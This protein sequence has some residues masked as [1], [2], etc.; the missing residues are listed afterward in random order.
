M[1]LMRHLFVS[2]DKIVLAVAA[3]ALTC[4]PVQVVLAQAD[5]LSE[6]TDHRTQTVTIDGIHFD[7]PVGTE[8]EKV[9]DQ[10]FIRWPVAADFDANGALIVLESNWNRQTVQQ[11]LESQP[12]A[13]VRLS[14]SDHDG[15]FDKR[16]VIADKLSFSAGVLVYGDAIFV[17]APPV[18]LKLTD[19]D[20][21]GFFDARETWHDGGTL[22]YCANDLHGPFLGPDGWI[23]WTKGAFAEQ[24][25]ET[26]LGKKVTSK[27]AH[28]L[29]RHPNGGPVDI[30][31]TGGM[32]NPV[33]VA[34]LPNGERIFCS[35][36]MHHPGDGLRDGI[37][38]AIYGSLFGKSH[39]PVD[40]HIRTGPLFD[41]IV[42]L[43][44]AAPASVMHAGPHNLIHSLDLFSEG[45]QTH[46]KI[47]SSQFNLQRLQVHSLAPDGGTFRTETQELISADRIDFHPVDCLEDKDGSLLILDTGGWYDLCCPSSGS[48]GQVAPGGIY[49]LKLSSN[50]HQRT[51]LVA[52][53]A[54]AEPTIEI[55]EFWKAARNLVTDP[56]DSQ[57]IDLVIR[58]LNNSNEELR[59]AAANLISLYRWDNTRPYLI[60]MLKGSNNGASPHSRRLAAECLGRLG[61]PTTETIQTLLQAIEIQPP[62]RTLDHAVLYALIELDQEQAMREA[63]TGDSPRQQ[64]A[65]LHVL[66]QT[67]HIMP[68]DAQRLFEL[69]KSNDP[70]V[71]TQAISTL[72]KQPQL[73][74][75]SAAY[76]NELWQSEDPVAI[77][78]LN[79]I[80]LGWNQQQ[81]VHRLIETG[82]QNWLELSEN[83]QQTLTA[84]LGGMQGVPLPA[85]WRKPLAEAISETKGSTLT[86]ANSLGGIAWTMPG[87]KPVVEALVQTACDPDLDFDSR[88]ALLLLLPKQTHGVSSA[89]VNEVIE[90]LLDNDSDYTTRCAVAL[91]NIKLTDS[92][93]DRLVESLDDLSAGRLQNAVLAI[94]QVNEGS[95][96]ERLIQKLPVLKSARSL[97]MDAILGAVKDRP[98]SL[99]NGF[100]ELTKQLQSP[101][102]DIEKVV[103]EYLAKL[104][105]GDHL[106]GY[107]VFRSS[108]ASCSGCH[109][110]GYVGGR[111]GP[112]LTRIGRSRS[113][114]D[115]AEAI[116][117]PNARLEQSYQSTQVLTDDGRVFNGLPANISATHLQLITGVDQ[118]ES[119]PLNEIERREPSPIS[120][121][122]SGFDSVLTPQQ[123]ADLLAFLQAAR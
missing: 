110:V 40:G 50:N 94:L 47:I 54:T 100:A 45:L 85:T 84:V 53:S 113:K 75:K 112:E 99:R 103:N 30:L 109:R 41:P 86:L 13:L 19:P 70:Q 56:T 31:M 15:I 83:Q 108:K 25:Y 106:E 12:H 4:N 32:D 97:A 49:R 71:Q 23:Y 8:L 39:A 43:G 96:D 68:S 55:T 102:D 65:A 80:M 58:N 66:E 64:W 6:S 98:E 51:G 59:Q 77:E 104:P 24:S 62:N 119:I 17:S 16:K 87:D 26:L 46:Y 67:G 14:D 2:L 18:I 36:F 22:T 91:N 117:F 101:P 11:Q 37:G 105:P 69:A 118:T 95:L 79:K 74:E 38:H 121:M 10:P 61:N 76:L 88:L 73:A 33:D 35:T 116:L 114:Y 60:S 3:L 21:D 63:L 82:L 34:F 42:E 9:G 28:L 57:T 48:P 52:A 122:P 29:R 90:G 1:L 123:F 81:S 120:I 111:I 92:Q 115:L 44:P 107:Q 7:I 78:S 72:T 89:V 27:A 20:G 93:A 5:A